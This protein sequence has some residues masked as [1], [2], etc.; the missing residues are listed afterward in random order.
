MIHG[1]NR[2]EQL[3]HSSGRMLTLEELNVEYEMD[4]LRLDY[5]SLMSAIPKD[6]L[7]LITDLVPDMIRT[8]YE[9]MLETATVN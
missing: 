6:W 1:V 2:V 8:S 3:I 9:K 4:L 5:Y 7:S